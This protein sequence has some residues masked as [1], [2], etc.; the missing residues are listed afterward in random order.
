LPNRSFSAIQGVLLVAGAGWLSCAGGPAP[1]DAPLFVEVAAAAGLDFSHDNGATGEFLFPELM[2]AGAALVDVDNDGL[3]DVYLVQSGP[4]PPDPDSSTGANR[5]YRNRGDGT[6]EE[7]TD[8]GG[9]GDRGYGVGVTAA[10]Y[11]RDGDADL[12]VTNLGRNT[13]L[14][15]DGAAGF[16]DVTTTAGVGDEGYST[17]AVFADIDA[18]GDLD[19]Y[20]CNYVAWTRAIE[21]ACYA[22]NGIR[23]YCAPSA[24]GR[25]AP[26]SLYRNEGDGTF[27][28]V[29]R[30][31]GI[32]SVSATGLGT[33]AAD[34]DD[35]GDTDIYVANDQM[36]NFLWVNQGD[37][38]FRDEAL[39]RGCALNLAGRPEAGMGIAINDI[40]EDGDWDLFLVHLSGETNTFYRNDGGRFND[41][42]EPRGLGA[43]SKTC[44]GFGVGAI[45]FDCDGV[46]DLFVANGKVRLAGSM[47]P[48][49]YGE[50]N[51]L[52][53]GLAD[54]TFRDITDLGGPALDPVEVS[55]S[56]AFGDYDNDGDVD[57]L[58]A[59]NEG[60]V[61]LL[62]NE[63]CEGRSSITVE[64]AGRDTDRDGIGA[65]VT[66][67]AGGRSWMRRV[68]P[69]Y[70]YCASNDPRVHVGLGD[71]TTVDRITVVWPGGAEQTFESVEAR[72]VLRVEQPQ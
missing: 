12:Y 44:T 2:Q 4:I 11:D 46:L 1:E 42:T 57:I 5:L 66:V 61:R 39:V 63:A 62:R 29:S 65:R 36:A 3:L 9:A 23:D 16:V 10:D 52:F 43:P 38:T 19:L 17:S 70:S 25:P 30:S 67:E 49:D 18:D 28:D 24:Y 64:L 48:G 69:G 37:G 20:V 31:S 58:I 41:D 7:L 59:N 45:D 34:F 33:V 54:G 72:G 50:R 60:P 15:N 26:D 56:A 22:R 40:E 55:R 14:R 53:Q 71:V 68:Q 13:L 6:F 47:E 8:G 21:R 51:Q 27:T 32:R 35:D